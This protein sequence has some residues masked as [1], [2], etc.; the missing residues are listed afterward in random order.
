[1]S[2]NSRWIDSCT[3]GKNSRGFVVAVTRPRVV[4]LAS[5]DY[6]F[7]FHECR[8]HGQ[9]S[10]GF[11]TPLAG[12]G[13]G[14]QIAWLRQ[15]HHADARQLLAQTV[16]QFRSQ[17]LPLGFGQLGKTRFQFLPLIDVDVHP[18]HPLGLSGL[19]PVHPADGGQPVDRPIRSDDAVFVLVG[20]VPFRRSQDLGH[21][22]VTI[23]RVEP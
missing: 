2:P 16:M 4:L 3:F 21:H 12:K 22:A 10:Y 18:E 17:P 19:V 9:D 8:K 15:L 23:K 1:M 14:E 20:L 11:E 13:I 7:G 6:L 5:R